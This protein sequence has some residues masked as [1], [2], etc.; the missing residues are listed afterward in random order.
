MTH[1]EKHAIQHFGLKKRK[2]PRP[3]KVFGEKPLPAVKPR[4]NL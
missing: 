2:V 4:A 3:H 1:L